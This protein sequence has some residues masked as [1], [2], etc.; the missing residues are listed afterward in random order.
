MSALD[1]SLGAAAF[2]AITLRFALPGLAL[3][4]ALLALRSGHFN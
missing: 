2:L 4:A 3:A 1:A